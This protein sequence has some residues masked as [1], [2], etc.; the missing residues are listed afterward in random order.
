MNFIN[1]AGLRNLFLIK[2]FQNIAEYERENLFNLKTKVD[3]CPYS[4]ILIGTQPLRDDKIIKDIHLN[5]IQQAWAIVNSTQTLTGSVIKALEKIK[6]IGERISISQERNDIQLYRL[7]KPSN[8]PL[9]FYL[10]REDDEDGIPAY[11]MRGLTNFWQFDLGHIPLHASA[12]IHK[13]KLFI[14]SGP[15]GSGKSTIAHLSLSLNDEIIDHDQVMIYPIEKGYS[16][17]GW[18]YALKNCDIPIAAFF[19]IIQADNDHLAALPDLEMAKLVWEQSLEITGNLLP[20]DSYHELL[21]R[22][23]VFART[24]PGYEMYF[25]MGAGFWNLIDTELVFG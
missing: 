9:F 14:F 4:V 10:V 25:Q 15:S 2:T 19:R 7:R 11:I 5:I 23:A 12:V 20:A 22:I 8:S 18:G 3:L 1:V 13:D 21:A 16:A 17:N 24:T 6:E